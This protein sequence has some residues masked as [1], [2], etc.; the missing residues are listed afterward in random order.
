MSFQLYNSNFNYIYNT[1]KN[2]EKNEYREYKKDYRD[3]VF[4]SMGR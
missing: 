1:Y 4:Y 2:I 3:V